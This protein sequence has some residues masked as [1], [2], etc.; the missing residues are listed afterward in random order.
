MTSVS[1]DHGRA[2]FTGGTVVTVTLEEVDGGVIGYW[3]DA[4]PMPMPPVLIKNAD[5]SVAPIRSVTVADATRLV[6]EGSTANDRIDGGSGADTINGNA[7]HDLLG[8]RDGN[9]LL[10]GGDGH[11]HL[12]GGAGADTLL[13]GTG[14]DYLNGG[15]GAD[16]LD[17]GAGHDILAG[18]AGADVFRLRFAE[19]DPQELGFGD[20]IT[21]FTRRDGDVIELVGFPGDAAVRP[22]GNGVYGVYQ[23]ENLIYRFQVAQPG[24]DAAGKPTSTPILDLAPGDFVF[25]QSTGTAPGGAP[26]PAPA[27]RPVERVG[28]VETN[29]S[30]LAFA[31]D[32]TAEATVASRSV[33]TMAPDGIVAANEEMMTSLYAT[34]ADGW[35]IA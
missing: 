16:L 10:S 1:Y 6:A 26:Q 13:G 23:G 19:Y 11:D 5:G 14:G 9:D 24:T 32:L 4:V 28:F 20:W 25:L 34:P 18:G 7:G 12:G 30:L 31:D 8:G 3:Q 27:P 33:S 22:I 17:G 35:V 29:E 2:T 21:D 15:I